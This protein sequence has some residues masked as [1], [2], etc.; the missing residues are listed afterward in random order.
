MSSSKNIVDTLKDNYMP[1]AM[2]VIISR[3][4]PQIDGFKPSHRKLLYTMYEMNLLKSGKTK[5]ANVVG[6]TMKLNPHG[7]MAIYETMVRMTKNNESL[8]HPYVDSK[9]NFG[10]V[11]SR[12]MKFAAARYTEVSLM[13]ICN[14]I[15]EDINKDT[16]DFVDNYDGKL[17]EPVLLPTKFPNILVNPNKGIAVGMASAIPSFNLKEVIDFTVAYLG[18]SEARPED[19]IIAPDLPTGGEILLDKEKMK[20]ILTTGR[21]SFAIRG[22][23]RVDKKAGIIEITEIPYTTTIESIIEKVVELM[24]SGK[25]K[26][27]TDIRDETDLQGLKITIDYRKS[28]D[29]HKLMLKL[30]KSTPLEDSF[31]CNFNILIEKRPMVLGVKDIVRHWVDFRRDTLTRKIAFEIEKQ[32]AKLNLLLGLKSI[33]VDIDKVIKII[34]G[35]ETEK[36][37][38]PTLKSV[39]SLNDDQAEYISEIKLRNLNKEYILK[40]LDEIKVL[41]TEIEKGKKILESEKL[42]NKEIVTDLKNISKKYGT[43]RKTTIA[44]LEKAVFY[45]EVEEED[46]SLFHIF[47]T[48]DGYFKKITD[49]SLKRSSEQKIKDDDEMLDSFSSRNQ[50]IIWVMTDQSN[51][52]QLKISEMEEMRSSQLGIYLPNQLNFEKNENIIRVLNPSEN[53]NMII[54][55]YAN[56]KVAKVDI[57]AYTTK[58]FRKKLQNI[59]SDKSEIVDM[60]PAKE[61]Q[62]LALLL[63]N[64]T[65]IRFNTDL[66]NLVSSRGSQGVQVARINKTSE[67]IKAIHKEIDMELYKEGTIKIPKAPKKINYNQIEV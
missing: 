32:N 18:N 28:Q 58:G 23:Y 64:D 56:G 67:V 35:T 37:V 51:L 44:D 6:Q 21:G 59:Y 1:Y 61:D 60:I 43:E 39:F 4:I 19:Y 54:N 53:Y 16:V 63:D 36:E 10:K 42:Q 8:L 22:K 27:I 33:L 48:K 20:E 11:Y 25:V 14:E 24:K 31:G 30:F 15:F 46:N 26:E 2:S 9:G 62:E 12:D 57:N 38:I 5:S 66:I 34:R 55:V 3:A 47:V 13:E 40:R 7:D 49:I 45:D 41:E 17:K 65:Y 29:P 52:Y 50:D